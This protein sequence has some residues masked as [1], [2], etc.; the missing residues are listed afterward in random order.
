MADYDVVVLGA[1]PGGYVAAIRCAQ[2][3]L[4][5]AVVEEKY[6]GGVCLNVGCKMCIRDSSSSLDL[7][8]D[9]YITLDGGQATYPD[10]TLTLDPTGAT[11]TSTIVGSC[12]GSACASRG[13][14]DAA[15]VTFTPEFF[16]KDAVGNHATGSATAALGMY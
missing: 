12:I 11:I 7:G 16:L 15:P 9:A 6:W 5:A 10:A 1:G 8:S 3:G 2:L 4:R 13:P 14:G